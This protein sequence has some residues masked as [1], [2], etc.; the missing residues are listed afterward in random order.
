MIK[1]TTGIQRIGIYLLWMLCAP[2]LMAQDNT[3][4]FSESFDGVTPPALPFGWSDGSGEWETSSS[5]ASSGSGANNVTVSGAQQAALRTPG[6]NLSGLTSGS[7][8]Y[9]A[10]RTSTYLQDSL[11]VQA[12]LDGG[13]TFSITLLDRGEALPAADGSYELISMA[14]PAA[15]LGQA[16][17]VLEFV[18]LGRQHI[19]LEYSDR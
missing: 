9:L 2:A 8:E 7:I 16:N 5:V 14:V 10:R 4:F 19:G 15:L 17:V 18:A 1:Y 13:T 11:I 3:L 12:S 6:L